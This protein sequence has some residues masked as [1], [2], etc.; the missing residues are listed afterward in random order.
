[1]P[2]MKVLAAD[3]DEGVLLLIAATFGYGDDYELLTARD[4]EQAIRLARE[5]QPDLLFLD[6]R[7]PKK[8]GLQV[9]RELKQDPR[10]R[11]QH[12]VLL[13]AMAQDKDR[14]DGLL[15]GADDYWVKPFSPGRMLSKAAEVL[16]Q[17]GL[18]A[19]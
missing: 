15:A 16:Q 19:P 5:E 4:G 12:I 8:G 1:M 13:S 14:R 6:V 3:D 10:T 18:S 2:K 11:G 7:M 9:C 17:K